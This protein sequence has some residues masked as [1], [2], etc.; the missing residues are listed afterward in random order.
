MKLQKRIDE[1]LV[2]KIH[3]IEAFRPV[4]SPSARIRFVPL[5]VA[6]VSSWWKPYLG[7]IRQLALTCSFPNKHRLT[8][9]PKNAFRFLALPFVLSLSLG[10]SGIRLP[11]KDGTGKILIIGFGIVSIPENKNTGVMAYQTTS[12]GAHLSSDPISRLNLGYSNVAV[13][14]VDP[15]STDCYV[16]SEFTPFGKVKTHINPKPHDQ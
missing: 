9:F 14:S 16:E 1:K 11:N 5:N 13:T 4:I 15:A 8:Y 6:P 10:C 12:I 3:S 2:D 7:S